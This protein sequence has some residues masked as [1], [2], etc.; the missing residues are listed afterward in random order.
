MHYI[1][2]AFCVLLFGIAVWAISDNNK[3]AE[4]LYCDPP[5]TLHEIRGHWICVVE[6][7]VKS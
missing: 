6:P 2:A 1:F 7:K 3:K 4:S 5:F